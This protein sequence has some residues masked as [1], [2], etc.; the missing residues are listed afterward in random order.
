MQ[1]ISHNYSGN[2]VVNIRTTV[3]TKVSAMRAIRFITSVFYLIVK[4][5][6]SGNAGAVRFFDYRIRPFDEWEVSIDEWM[7]CDSPFFTSQIAWRETQK[8]PTV[9]LAGIVVNVKLQEEIRNQF[10]G[11]LIP[12]VRTGTRLPA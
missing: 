12:C 6:Y 1:E 3:L 10:G 2:P 9:R 5:M 4:Q 11:L 8:I 7:K